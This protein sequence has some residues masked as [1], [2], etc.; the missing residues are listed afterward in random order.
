MHTFCTKQGMW[1]VCI[2]IK[3]HD[4][5]TETSNLSIRLWHYMAKSSFSKVIDCK[6]TKVPYTFTNVLLEKFARSLELHSHS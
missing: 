2:S 5:H 3:N 4:T 6:A 1:S